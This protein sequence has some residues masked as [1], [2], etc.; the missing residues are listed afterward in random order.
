MADRHRPFGRP[1]FVD[2]VLIVE[3]RNDLQVVE[4]GQVFRDGIVELELALDSIMMATEVTGLVMD[5]MEKM[6][7][8][9]I[10]AS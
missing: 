10:A 5:A 4:A 1:R 7:F 3:L 6:A 2:C 9:G 8:T